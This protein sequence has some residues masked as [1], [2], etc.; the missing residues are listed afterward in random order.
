MPA[1]G[2]LSHGWK[3][4]L[5]PAPSSRPAGLDELEILHLSAMTWT[6]SSGFTYSRIIMLYDIHMGFG[7]AEK[8]ASEEEKKGAQAWSCVLGWNG[9]TLL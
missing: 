6:S 1:M 4:L 9:I 8:M 7:T 3:Y 2:W 5:I